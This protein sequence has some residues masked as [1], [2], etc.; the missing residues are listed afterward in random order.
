MKFAVVLI[1]LLTSLL[2]VARGDAIT[3]SAAISMKDALEE[4][5]QAY[6]KRTGDDVELNFGSSGQL[7]T[8]I[9][10]GAPVD[11]F[12]SAAEEQMDQLARD[13][14]IDPRTRVDVAR[15]RLV[16]IVPG[17]VTG[18][19]M[20]FE[21]LSDQRF[22]RISIGQP[23]SVPAGKYAMQVL[24]TLGLT[25]AVRDRLVY[26]ANV[27]QV[28]SYVER[29]EVEAGIVYRTDALSARNVSV[30]ATADESWHEPIRYPAAVVSASLHRDA[31]ERFV[32][33]L[34]GDEAQQTLTRHGFTPVLPATQP[35][36]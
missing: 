5:A 29:G 33:F 18:A 17:D 10:R 21:G 8:Q 16:L 23:E 25:D 34:R 20:S 36:R 31:G 4:V 27:R 35:A 2:L 32:T 11:V 14:Q 24:T 15:N 30:V 12:I 9:A 22:K 19:R 26:G 6:E 3:V 13:K 7:M 28:L 1:L